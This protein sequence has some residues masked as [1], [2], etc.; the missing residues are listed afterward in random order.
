MNKFSRHAG[1]A[2]LLCAAAALTACGGGSSQTTCPSRLDLLIASYVFTN[3]ALNAGAPASIVPTI[4]TT[5]S[6][7]AQFTFHHTLSS[8]TLPTGLT[9]NTSTGNIGGTPSGTLGVY[10]YSVTLTADCV[11]GSITSSASITVQ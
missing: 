7:A 10:P 9:L 3:V 4:T 11:P 1:A 5:S 6:G 2:I 8:G